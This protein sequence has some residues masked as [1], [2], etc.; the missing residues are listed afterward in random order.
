MTFASRFSLLGAGA[1]ALLGL[2]GCSA[3]DNE[4]NTDVVAGK[5]LF[6]QKCGSCHTLARADTKGVVGPNLDHAFANAVE[7][8]FGETAIRGMVR[9]MIDIGPAKHGDKV[10]MRPDI[11]TGQ[12]AHDVAAYVARSVD[13]PGKDTGLL[14]TQAAGSNKPAVA[15]NGTL[16]I[17]A[18]P[19]GQLVYTNKTATAPAGQLTIDMP[20]KS[21]TPHN[22]A[23]DGKGQG[24]IVT[25][26][27]STFSATFAP[28][29]YTYYCQ[30]PGHKQAGMTGILTVK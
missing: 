1:A 3:K 28:G 24:K 17:A 21:G 27:T 29:K 19:G 30:V 18:D 11:V 9:Q 23:I 12:D 2:A 6:V 8:G 7:E 4:G 25:S 26:G 20:N 16:T 10:I 22:I 15:A 13:K 14:V 5:K